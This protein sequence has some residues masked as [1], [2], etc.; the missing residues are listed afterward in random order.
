MTD[1]LPAALRFSSIAAPAGWSCTTPAVGTNGTVTCNATTL[2]N[3]ATATF[4]LVTT[5]APNAT[6]PVTNTASA[7]HSGNDANSGNS[8]GP[9]TPT[10]ITPSAS[11][12]LSLAKSTQS[13]NA[14]TGSTITYTLTVNNAGPSPATNV[15][16][17]DTIASSLTLLTATPSQGSCSGTTTVTC[18]LGT[19][20]NLASATVTIT[21]RVVATSG[22][23]ANS[24][25][26]S[27]TESDPNGGNNTGTAPPLTV[28]IP[29]QGESQIPT[30]SEWALL[31]LAAMLVLVAT[32]KV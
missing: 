1:I 25:T 31:A 12:D 19:L 13:T 32:R 7:S 10:A 2:A 17:T 8:S 21:A 6:G 14:V 18:N 26:V 9:S 3:G 29:T 11:A 20:A 28:V 22:T 15:V 16:V 4:T 27:A 23:V 30:L 24:A 5:V